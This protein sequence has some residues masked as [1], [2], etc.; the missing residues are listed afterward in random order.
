MNST[1]AHADEPGLLAFLGRLDRERLQRVFLVHGDPVRQAA[2]AAALGREGY[3]GGS[4][5]EPGDSVTVVRVLL[6][7]SRRRM[8]RRRHSTTAIRIAESSTISPSANFRPTFPHDDRRD[9]PRFQT[10]SSITIRST[11]TSNIA[12][13]GHEGLLAHGLQVLILPPPAPA[14]SRT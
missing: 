14:S 9:V 2:L 7:G 8:L 4:I 13:Q 1:V 11:T 12:V 6:G 10:V 5:P 3:R